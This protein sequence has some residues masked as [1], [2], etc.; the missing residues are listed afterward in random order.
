MNRLRLELGFSGRR[1]HELCCFREMEID[2]FAAAITD[3][4]IVTI[5]LAVVTRGAVAEADFVNEPG[6][7]QIAQRVVDGCV[8]DARQTLAR[9]FEDV[10][11]GR[12]IFAFENHL[13]H[14]LSLR[15]QFMVAGFLLSLHSGLRLILNPVIVKRAQT[16]T[17]HRRTRTYTDRAEPG[18]SLLSLFYACPCLSVSVCG[19]SSR[20]A[21]T[22]VTMLST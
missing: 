16:N 6:L 7:F 21:F 4:V 14:R 15:R 1:L 11:G 19:T 2:Q 3:S 12:V 8:A 17:G 22:N 5:R 13:K 9:R 18:L 10:A 20:F